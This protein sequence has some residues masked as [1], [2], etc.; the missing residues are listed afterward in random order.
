MSGGGAVGLGKLN[1][2]ELLV[3]VDDAAEVVVGVHESDLILRFKADS[4]Y[5]K[6]VPSPRQSSH[7][8]IR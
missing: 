1:G 2:V 3:G 4:A 8:S 5:R 6:C 7:V